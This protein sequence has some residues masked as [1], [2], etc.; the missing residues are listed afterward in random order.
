MIAKGTQK[1]YAKPELGANLVL[2]WHL[3]TCLMLR[4]TDEE[5][6]NT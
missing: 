4:I 2:V 3:L 6:Q 5:D 1:P